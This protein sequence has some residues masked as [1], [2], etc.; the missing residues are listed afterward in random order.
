VRRQIVAYIAV[1]PP[2]E[3]VGTADCKDEGGYKSPSGSKF[4][5]IKDRLPLEV[6][7][8]SKNGA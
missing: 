3:V 7:N 5:R 4:H 6:L 2:F 8:A 1:D